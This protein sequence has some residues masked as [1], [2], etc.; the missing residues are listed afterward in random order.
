VEAVHKARVLQ[1]DLILMD[2]GL[3]TLNGLEAT[4]EICRFSPG[5]KIIIVS[6]NIDPA[7]IQAAFDAGAKG[8]VLKS[9]AAAELFAAVET[10]VRGEFF[11]GGGLQGFAIGANRADP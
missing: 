11:V 3:P 10:V 2:I 6:N 4:R 8:Y 7:V 9:L 5:S 1:P